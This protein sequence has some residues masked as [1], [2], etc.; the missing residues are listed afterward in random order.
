VR[1]TRG[2]RVLRVALA[3]TATTV[4]IA[5]LGGCGGKEV[6][7]QAQPVGGGIDTKNVGGK[8]VT[9]GPSGP[10]QGAPDADLKYENGD[11]GEM[12][13]L[14]INTLADVY[15]YWNEALPKNFD[16]QKFEPLKRLISYDSNGKG[17][18]VCGQNTAG[19]VNAF[20]C[21]QDDSISWDRGELLP[22]LE[23]Q[24]GPMAVVTVLAHEVGHAV[25]Y[26]LG[27]KSGINPSTPTIVKEQQADCFTGN[28]FAYIAE[29]RSKHF[30]LNTGEGLNL[31]LATMFFIR[32]P[33]GTSSTTRG[34]HGLAF[35]RVYA[36]QEGYTK[37]PKRCAA[38]NV[39]EING[40]I[41]EKKRSVDD[42]KV[43]GQA[44]ITKDDIF[45]AFKEGLEEAFKDNEGKRPEIK[46]NGAKCNEGEATSPAAYC[47]DENVVALDMDKLK[48]IA[49]P[50]KRGAKPGES[51][52]GI[53]D[54]AA[55]AEITSRYALGVQKALG[56]SLE[57]EDVGLRTACLTG[58][59]AAHVDKPGP[60]L[61]L[62]IGDLDEAVAELLL[63]DSLIA[64]DV[65]G[66][67]TPVGFARIEAFRIGY[68]DGAGKC[69]QV[70]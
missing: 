6:Q 64:A 14:S 9:D 21:G 55:F 29:G 63:E 40:R 31:V 70:G 44:D 37:D 17:I 61:R 4:M 39:D 66:K 49:T 50:P 10:R 32:D 5:Q 53:G 26:R 52:T 69:Q 28:F 36:F 41:A 3:L 67:K 54:F 24:F 62:A 22:M 38:M 7:G 27:E 68:F 34:A 65:K 33:A 12:D 43:Q 25:Q 16:G 46:T 42:E 15:D 47:P 59:W 2:G 35:D 45:K 23:D 11:G 56:G 1:T 57:G 51:G 18:T 20:Y 58:A 8:P 48:K 19:F 13:K 60:R 30:Q